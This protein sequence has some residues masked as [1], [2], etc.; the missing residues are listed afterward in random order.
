MVLVVVVLLHIQDHFFFLTLSPAAGC[1][2][3]VNGF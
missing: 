3:T 1:E 2:R